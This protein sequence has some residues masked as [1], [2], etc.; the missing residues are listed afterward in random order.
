MY[1]QE[2]T[3]TDAREHFFGIGAARWG[4]TAWQ[5]ELLIKAFDGLINNHKNFQLS[6][7]NPPAG[8]PLKKGVMTFTLH[9]AGNT[10]HYSSL[11]WDTKHGWSDFK[12]NRFKATGGK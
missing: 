8:F 1:N 10:Q 2:K 4:Y 3:I 6:N 5:K 9:I 7:I 11:S 12:L